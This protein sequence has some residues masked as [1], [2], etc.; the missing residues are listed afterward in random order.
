MAQKEV[1]KQAEAG[2]QGATSVT[3][4]WDS[5]GGEMY[6]FLSLNEEQKREGFRVQFLIDKP[7]RETPN[8]FHPTETDFWFDVVYDKDLYTWTISQ[9]SIVMEL[10]K[11]KPLK[12]KIFDVKLVPV[13][14]E[15]KKLF[16][17]YK[18][19]DRYE[20]KYIEIKEPEIKR[21]E[22]SAT[23]IGNKDDPVSVEDIE[24]V[25]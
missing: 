1:N 12:N 25:E 13:D 17:K 9:K 14:E 5:Y 15:F 19:N 11:H 4:K 16:P 20:L 3:P 23:G 7:R 10:Q 22:S 8:K 21:K 18:G 24:E 6:P 2:T